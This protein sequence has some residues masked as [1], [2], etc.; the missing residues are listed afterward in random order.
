VVDLWALPNETAIQAAPL[1]SLNAT[2]A[3]R[4]AGFAKSSANV[5]GHRLR[6]KKHVGEAMTKALADGIGTTKSRVI[7]EISRLAFSTAG[8]DGVRLAAQDQ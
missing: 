7:E 6:R 4:A 3:A 5:Q 1:D 2:Q 8:G